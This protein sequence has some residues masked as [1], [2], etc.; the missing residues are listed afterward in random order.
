MEQLMNNATTQL[1]N[2]LRELIME[3]VENKPAT[4]AELIKRYQ[5][6]RCVKADR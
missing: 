2:P 1:E 5:D 3:A 6:G 4:L